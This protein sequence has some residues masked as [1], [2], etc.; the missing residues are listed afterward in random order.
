MK[1]KGDVPEMCQVDVPEITAQARD[2]IG[3]ETVLKAEQ[4]TVTEGR[5]SRIQNLGNYRKEMKR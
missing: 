2:W 3:L 4:S 5:P 1:E